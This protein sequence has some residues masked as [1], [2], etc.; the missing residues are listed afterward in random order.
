MPNGVINGAFSNG[1]TETL[2]QVM[3]ATFANNQG[4]VANGDSTFTD[5]VNSG[6][7][8]VSQPNSSGAGSLKA[9]A[10]ELSNT[11]IG[12][13]LVDLITV[14]TNYQGDCPG[15]QRRRPAHQ[16]P[17]DDDAAA[18]VMQIASIEATS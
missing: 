15:H 6:P 16:R 5:G 14:S 2:G 4:L 11:D 9:G 13:S 18:R 1:A 17:A 7:A 12:T 8:I 3:L 10:V